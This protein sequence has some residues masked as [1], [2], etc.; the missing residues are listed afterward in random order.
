ML[1][2][3]TQ[4][5]NAVRQVWRLALP[6]LF[7]VSA[8]ICLTAGGCASSSF[9]SVNTEMQPFTPEE[10][11]AWDQASTAEYRMHK[12]DV[13]DVLFEYYPDMDQIRMIVLPDGRVAL[14]HIDRTMAVGLTIS[15]LDSAITSRYAE[16]YLDPELSIVIREFGE[17]S[18][19]VLGEVFKPGSVIL[20]RE[21]ASVLQAVAE[22]GGFTEDASMSE[23]LHVRITPEGYQYRHLDLSHLEKRAFM[24]PEIYDLQP[25]DVIYVPQSAMGD[26]SF[27]RRTMLAGVLSVGDLFWDIY[28]ITNIDKIDRLVR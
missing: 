1:G 27:F 21:N 25:Y 22:A 14:P 12:G 10:Q 5:E 19:Y 4:P 2:S 28:A 23:V 18:V 20:Q 26:F 13:F 11:L 9:R 7:L 24:A 3:A 17:L 8:G 15:Q 16:E 6:A